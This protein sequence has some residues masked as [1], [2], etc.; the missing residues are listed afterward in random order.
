LYPSL[1]LWLETILSRSSTDNCFNLM[2]WFLLWHA[3]STVVP[4]IDSCV[5]P[6]H[7]QS[8]SF[9]RAGFQLSCRNSSKMINGNRKH[10][11]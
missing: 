4:Y 1:D 7:V 6:N 2:A 3:R 9:I 10:L 11:S 5:F 8:I